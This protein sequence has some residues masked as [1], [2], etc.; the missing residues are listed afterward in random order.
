M[1]SA[2]KSKV[3]TKGQVTIPRVLRKRLGI[4]TGQVLEFTERGGHLIAT[5]GRTED[6]FDKWQ[7][8]FKRQRSTEAIIVWLRGEPDAV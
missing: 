1:T 5:K 7:G 2:F 8:A 3:T 4:R 6:A